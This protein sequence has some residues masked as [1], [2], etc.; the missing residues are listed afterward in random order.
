M[1]TLVANQV[2]ARQDE[3]IFRLSFPADHALLGSYRDEDGS[4]S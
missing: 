3:R 2:P 1:I 4:I